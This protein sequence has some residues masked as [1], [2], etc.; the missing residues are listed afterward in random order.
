MEFKNYQFE[1]RFID[2]EGTGDCELIVPITVQATS[3]EQARAL[4]LIQAQDIVKINDE[5]HT[6][7]MRLEKA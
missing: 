7:F 3:Y 2:V 4:A 5:D 1:A 6:L